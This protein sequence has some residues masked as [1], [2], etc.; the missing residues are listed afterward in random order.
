M[1]N[2]LIGIPARYANLTTDILMLDDY[3]TNREHRKVAEMI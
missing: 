2:T 3:L 1:N